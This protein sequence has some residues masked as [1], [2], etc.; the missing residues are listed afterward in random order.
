MHAKTIVLKF[1]FYSDLILIL[2]CVKANQVQFGSLADWMTAGSYYIKVTEPMIYQ[3]KL[4]H[5]L[6]KQLFE[7]RF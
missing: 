7:C 3:A 2:S 5:M 6:L 4:S 1:I